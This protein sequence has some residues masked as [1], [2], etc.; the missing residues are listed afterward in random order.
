[1]YV[2]WLIMVA[3]FVAFIFVSLVLTDQAVENSQAWRVEHTVPATLPPGR[4][5]GVWA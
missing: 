3:I 1:M 5:D 2:W 4:G